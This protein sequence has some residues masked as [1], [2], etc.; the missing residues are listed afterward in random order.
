MNQKI[1]RFLLLNQQQVLLY[2]KQS[3]QEKL[4]YP[5]NYG[6][7]NNFNDNVLSKNTFA[8]NDQISVKMMTIHAMLFITTY[9]DEIVLPIKRFVYLQ[10]LD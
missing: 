4:L 3:K 1:K 8:K 5:K 6:V 9:L 10:I 2:Q 7:A